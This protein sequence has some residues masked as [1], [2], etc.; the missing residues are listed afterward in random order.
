MITLVSLPAW[1]QALLV[2]PV[3]LLVLVVFQPQSDS[4][5]V[6]VTALPGLGKGGLSAASSFGVTSTLVLGLSAG[7]ESGSGISSIESIVVT[8]G[9]ATLVAASSAAVVF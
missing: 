6:V 8:G 3:L 7:T 9:W 4:R 5:A 2:L 1:S